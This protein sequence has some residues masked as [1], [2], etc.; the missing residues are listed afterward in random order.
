[1]RSSSGQHFAGLDHVRALAAFM[2]VTWHF[3]H[4]SNGNPV[5]FNEAPELGL[6][7]EG[8]VGVSL[9]MV[10]SGYLFAKLIAGRSIN[11]SA[12]LWNRAIRLLPLL[13]VVLLVFGVR[14]YRDNPVGFAKIVIGGA[15][16]PRLPNGG[17]SITAEAHFYLI[18]PLLLWATLKW[19]WAPVAMVGA[20]ICVRLAVLTSG[21]NVQDLAYWTIIGR[22][23]QFSL[24][25]FF[26]QQRVTGRWAGAALFGIAAI[27]Y[28]FDVMGGFYAGPDWPW[29]IIPMLE[30]VAFGA[31]ISWYDAN[32]IKSP[33]MGIVQKAGEYSY[34]IYLLHFFVVFAAAQFINTHVMGLTNLYIAL[35]WSLL[36]FMV[37]VG[38]GHVSY[39]LIEEPPLRFR[40]SY[41]KSDDG[42]PQSDLAV[43]SFAGG[44]GHGN[45]RHDVDAR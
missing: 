16:L 31:I 2:V 42:T 32:P 45:F 4:G 38:V 44:A 14:H 1:M 37:M 25:I 34:S 26:S 13:L 9:F 18:L 29:T 8:H 40:K 30:G 21:A 3:A 19:R 23:D 41:I 33:K 10:L 11:Y 6:L 35:P 15:V 5:P 36:F 24:G 27:Y 22:F 20:A 43:S 12:F 28:V 7:D 17:W 39:K